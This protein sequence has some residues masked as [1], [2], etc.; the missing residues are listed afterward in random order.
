MPKQKKK[1]KNANL[2]EPYSSSRKGNDCHNS[3]GDDPGELLD[4]DKCSQSVDN[5]IQCERC[6]HWYCCK[7]TGLPSSVM[8]IIL[9]YKQLH[10]FC[11]ACDK[12][13]IDAS[14]ANHSDGLLMKENVHDIVTQVGEAIKEANERIRKTLVETLQG[15]MHGGRCGNG[16]GQ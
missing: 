6:E 15:T 2:V 13:A 14:T 3:G 9:L 7:C 12:A 5:V 10:W 4:C 8:E 1:T 11:E 16:S